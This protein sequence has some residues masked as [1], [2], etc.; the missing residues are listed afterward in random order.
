VIGPGGIQ[1]DLGDAVV[2]LQDPNRQHVTISLRPNLEPGIYTVQWVSASGTDGDDAQG[3]YTF[4]VGEATPAATPATAIEPTPGPTV[5]AVADEPDEGGNFDSGA[6]GIS[7]GVG[8]VFAAL[9][10]LFWRLVRPKNPK[11]RS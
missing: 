7:V 4:R 10:F 11:F 3:S 2:D 5:T 8:L 9:I 6:Y 1:V